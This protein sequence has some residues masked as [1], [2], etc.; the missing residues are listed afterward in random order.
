MALDKKKT[1]AD[2]RAEREAEKEE[3]A[4]NRR[5]LLKSLDPETAEF[6]RQQFAKLGLTQ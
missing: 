1:L 2:F 5:K 6:T 3:Q 4:E